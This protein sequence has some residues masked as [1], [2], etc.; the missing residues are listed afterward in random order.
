[1]VSIVRNPTRAF[2]YSVWYGEKFLGELIEDDIMR[3][4]GKDTEK[5]YKKNQINFLVPK[6][7]IKTIINKKKYF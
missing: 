5:F 2:T 3:L 6:N 7:K 4:L 1:M